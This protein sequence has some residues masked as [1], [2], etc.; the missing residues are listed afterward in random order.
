MVKK[1]NNYVSKY[2]ECLNLNTNTN[3]HIH[4]KFSLQ[5]VW[6]A[7]PQKAK[8]NIWHCAT[9]NTTLTD[10]W[11]VHSILEIIYILF[12]GETSVPFLP[13]V[14]IVCIGRENCTSMTSLRDCRLTCP[15]NLSLEWLSHEPI[16]STVPNL[17]GPKMVLDTSE[18]PCR[19]SAVPLGA[20]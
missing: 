7:C 6:L 4:R 14:N 15:G 18:T 16:A 5:Y 10:I 2:T 1:C 9:L 20:P 11:M 8:P 17:L 19:P 13:Q 12:Y 3:V